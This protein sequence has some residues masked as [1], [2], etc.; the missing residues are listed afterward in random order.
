MTKLS[1]IIAIILIVLYIIVAYSINVWAT[2]ENDKFDTSYYNPKSV[3]DD[4]K[5]DSQFFKKAG[6]V[7]STIS[8]IGVVALVLGLTILGINFMLGSVEEKAEYKKVAMPILIGIVMFTS[9]IPILGIFENIFDD[10]KK[11]DV[12]ICPTCDTPLRVLSNGKTQCPVC[13][14]RAVE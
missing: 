2:E 11:N 8:V 7:L 5:G 12:V 13:D 6:I 3:I 1:K 9:I 10:V 4:T 14:F